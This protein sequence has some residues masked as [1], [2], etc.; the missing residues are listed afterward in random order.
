MSDRSPMTTL[1]YLERDGSYLMLHRIKKEHD[2]NRDKWI[3]I[4]G[5]FEGT[6]SPEECLLRECREET[7]LTLTSY[8]YRG[9]ITFVYDGKAEY[10]SLFTAD[11]WTG[12]MKDC[13]E[14]QLEWVRKEEIGK[15]NLWEGDRIFLA[16]LRETRAF[17]S[18]KLVY[19]VDG[20]LLE[21]I[22][23][24]KNLSSAL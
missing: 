13:D 23:D 6:E 21:A 14:G 1:C 5:H 20:K 16:L 15:R 11:A 19:D 9:L 4:G 18:L 22:L 7:G 8:Q 3:G 12:Q 24:G 2:V 10:M 17:F